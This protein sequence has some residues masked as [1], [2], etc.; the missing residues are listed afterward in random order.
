MPSCPISSPAFSTIPI[1][2]TRPLQPL[3]DA[4]TKGSLESFG[5]LI[6]LSPIL[7]LR[8]RAGFPGADYVVVQIDTDIAQDF[9]VVTHEAGK[10][11]RHTASRPE[12]VRCIAGSN[13]QGVWDRIAIV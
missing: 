1:S 12:R 2:L 11:H 9:G 6:M 5:A 10:S 4:T 7:S 13:R 8:I 3:T